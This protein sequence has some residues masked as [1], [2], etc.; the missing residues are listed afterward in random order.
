MSRR[1]GTPPLRPRPA[2]TAVQAVVFRPALDAAPLDD[3]QAIQED[4]LRHL[5]GRHGIDTGEWRGASTIG[6]AAAAVGQTRQTVMRW[7]REDKEFRDRVHDA[8]DN[9]IDLLMNAEY[10]RALKLGGPHVDRVR[11]YRVDS[12]EKQSPKIEVQFIDES[13]HH[14]P[15]AAALATDGLGENEAAPLHS[16]VLWTPDGE[17][18]PSATR[19]S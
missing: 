19:D 18:D 1:K 5:S 6:A 10:Q 17:N 13:S 9:A 11:G 14:L 15:E 16:A 7:I 8:L 12:A 3:I 2:Q 4:F